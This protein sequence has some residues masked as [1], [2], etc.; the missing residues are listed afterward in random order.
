MAQDR[1][2]LDMVTL[3]Q[4]LGVDAEMEADII[5]GLLEA[6]D[7]SSVIVRPGE[8]PNLGF[9]VQVS[10]ADLETAKRLIEEAQASGPEAAAE[11]EAASEE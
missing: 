6:N 9:E 10:K 5:H 11:A 7:I 1:D 4:S 8:F 2:D 3:Y